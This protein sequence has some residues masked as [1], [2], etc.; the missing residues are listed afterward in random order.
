MSEGISPCGPCTS[1]DNCNPSR[2]GD[3]NR[4]ALKLLSFDNLPKARGTNLIVS[5]AARMRRSGESATRT[6]ATGR[7]QIRRIGCPSHLVNLRPAAAND[8]VGA[9]QAGPRTSGCQCEAGHGEVIKELLAL[10]SAPRRRAS[11]RIAAHRNVGLALTGR[12]FV[13]TGHVG[14]VRLGSRPPSAMCLG[15]D[16]SHAARGRAWERHAVPSSSGV[17]DYASAGGGGAG[18]TSSIR[19]LSS[20][21]SSPWRVK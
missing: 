13:F 18:S 20:C 17:S 14:G 3:G 6:G 1:D 19:L 15:E 10:D 12:E 7:A 9:Q 5:F 16:R 2:M 11:L 4:S 21:S 8:L